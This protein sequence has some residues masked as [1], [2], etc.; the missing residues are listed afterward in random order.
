MR[1]ESWIYWHGRKQEAGGQGVKS[2]WQKTLE[3]NQRR[4]DEWLREQIRDWFIANPFRVVDKTA[5][6]YNVIM[7]INKK[8]A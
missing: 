2:E 7:E 5:P 8:P 4:Q 1:K 3:E 6:A